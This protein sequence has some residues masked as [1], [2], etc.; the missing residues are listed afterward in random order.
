MFISIFVHF[1]MSMVMHM[2]GEPRIDLPMLSAA[3]MNC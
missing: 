1:M 3:P 2:R